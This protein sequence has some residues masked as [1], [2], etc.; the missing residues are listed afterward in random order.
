MFGVQSALTFTGFVRIW[1]SCFSNRKHRGI[2][3][4]RLAILND[5]CYSGSWCDKLRSIPTDHPWSESAGKRFSVQHK[6]CNVC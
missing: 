5:S 6:T 3:P 1:E 4:A 2:G